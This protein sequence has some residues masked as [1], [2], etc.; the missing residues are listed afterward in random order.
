MKP[1]IT[2]FLSILMTTAFASTLGFAS[3][4]DGQVRV[5]VSLEVL[6]TPATGFEEKNNIEVVLYGY[7]LNGCYTL[8]DSSFEKLDDHTFRVHQ[9][10]LRDTTGVCADEASMPEHMKMFVPFTQ[11]VSFGR[12]S[13]GNYQFYYEKTGGGNRFRTMSVSKN[14]SPSVD[15]LPYAAV[16][17]ISA[18]DVISS[19]DH[20][21][22]KL[23]GVLNSSCTS[24]NSAVPLMRENDVI[25]LLPQITV[26]PNVLCTQVLTPFEKVV[27]LGL[28]TPGIYLLHTRSMNGRAVNQ[29]INVVN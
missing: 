8:A 3:D 13:A 20:V 17:A 24:L 15:T 4:Q 9:F 27:D 18:K 10:A 2:Y 6:L 16:S 21:I 14:I 11:E 26:D 12:L 7:L 25:V 29:V 23:T 5:E 1:L 19:S 28:L 22:V